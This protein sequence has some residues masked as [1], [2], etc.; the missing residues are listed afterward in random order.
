MQRHSFLADAHN[1]LLL[2]IDFQA[3]MSKAIGQWPALMDRATLLIEAAHQLQVPIL[4]TEQYPE[5]LGPTDASLLSRIGNTNVLAKTHFSACLE[6]EFIERLSRSGKNTLIL[7]GV[8]SHVCVLQTGLDLLAQGYKVHL[9]ADAVASRNDADKAIALEQFKAAGA[10][11]TSAETV[12]F[13]W[14]K[15]AKT[16]DF[17]TLLP[18]IK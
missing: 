7:A 8:E 5:G 3:G 15:Q 10:V 17:R 6:D 11:L 9:V 14:L 18:F 1:S 2:L 12:V 16:E 4:A 13:E